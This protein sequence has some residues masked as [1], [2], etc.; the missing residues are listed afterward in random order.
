MITGLRTFS[1]CQN[2]VNR[3]ESYTNAIFVGEPTAENK[4]FYGDAKPV[5]LPN[6]KLQV[7]LSFAW[8]QDKAPWENED[9]LYP[10]LSVDMSFLEY[11][12]NEDPVLEAIHSFDS[13]DF[14]IRPME[15][16][17]S[18][19]AQGKMEQ[20][21]IDVAQMIQDPRYKFFDFEGKFINAGNLLINQKQHNYAIQ[22][23]SF[24]T[25]VYPNSNKAWKG[26]ADGYKALGANEKAE[27]FY[28]KA[29]SVK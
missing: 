1:A 23:F 2:L 8:W 20:I 29:D 14:I 21:K 13:N 4:N 7:R 5:E 25:Q 6:S 24:I 11:T 22:I 27:E 26:L 10:Q 9:A 18:L 28:K 19:F 12:N 17:R 15:H 16:V 3:L